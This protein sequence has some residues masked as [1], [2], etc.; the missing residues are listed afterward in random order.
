MSE[1][2]FVGTA[3]DGK[4]GAVLRTDDGEVFYLADLERWPDALQRKR[5]KVTGLLREHKHVPDPVDQR[6]EIVQGAWGTQRVIENAKWSE[7]EE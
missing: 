5:V 1:Q 4:A 7:Y 3:F 2:S 6:G